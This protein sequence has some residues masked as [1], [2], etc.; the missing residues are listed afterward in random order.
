MLKQKAL[1]KIFATTL[2]MFI[3][4][5]IYTIPTT[6]NKN[7][8]RTNL[9]LTDITSLATNTVYLLNK[10]NYLVKTDVFIEGVTE[11]EK[12]KKI[13]NYLIINNPQNSDS[14]RGYLPKGT[15]VNKI[16]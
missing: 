7:I 5:T 1:K 6:N 2:T 4:L 13:I 16:K 8:L 10:N 15:K 9:E 11:E 3:I 14:L 12:I